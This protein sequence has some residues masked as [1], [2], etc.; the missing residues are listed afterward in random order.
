MKIMDVYAEVAN[1]VSLACDTFRLD[2]LTEMPE[3]IYNNA[4]EIV[5]KNDITFFFNSLLNLPE[6]N[7]CISEDVVKSLLKYDGNLLDAIY[8]VY[9]AKDYK[10]YE[11]ISNAVEI[12]AEFIMNKE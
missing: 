9:I 2:M 7:P 8:A 1:R 12:F 6:E 11:D 10:S 5:I 4:S 3:D